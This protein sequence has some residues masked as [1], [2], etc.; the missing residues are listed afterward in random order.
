MTDEELDAIRRVVNMATQGPWEFSFGADNDF[1]VRCAQDGRKIAVVQPSNDVRDA[2]A[3]FISQAPE[4]VD[5][6]LAEVDRLR[7]NQ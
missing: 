5:L 7:A 4:M 1:Y 3:R 6:L 2:N